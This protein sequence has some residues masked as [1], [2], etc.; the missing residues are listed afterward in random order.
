MEIATF[1]KILKKRQGA[2]FGIV[3]IFLAVTAIF[4]LAQTLK[5]RAVSRLLIVQE[6]TFSDPYTV[7]K[8]NQYISS[9]MAEAVSS[10][11]F[12]QSLSASSSSAINWNYFR[13]DYKQ[14]LKEWKK[15]IVAKNI[16]DTGVL[17]VSIYHSN[18]EQARQL[19]LAVNNAIINQNSNYQNLNNVKIKVI[20]EP[21]V[22][23][24]PVKP[25][26][27]LNVIAA[28]IFG[29]I[30]AS[31][32]IYSFPMSRKDKR[33]LLLG[34]RHVEKREAIHEPMERH[35]SLSRH[36]P[37]RVAEAEQR[38]SFSGNIHNIINR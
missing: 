4:T 28:I 21:T 22:S 18:P 10:G 15:T 36:V 33:R 19:A 13:G 26:L 23:S 14:Q 31:L 3:L 9:L 38:S 17:E 1:L 5:Y 8:S 34:V 7:A 29:L 25:N 6:G 11:S 35:E 30:A 32:Y 16:S 2:V 12:L 27:P 20:D 24:Y 37:I